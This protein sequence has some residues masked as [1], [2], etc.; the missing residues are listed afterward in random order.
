VF[1]AKGKLQIAAS[2]QIIEIAL[3]VATCAFPHPGSYTVLFHIDESI[4]CARVL[5]VEKIE[6]PRRTG[7]A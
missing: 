6:P 2:E 3:P 7:A 5:R 4:L 1:S